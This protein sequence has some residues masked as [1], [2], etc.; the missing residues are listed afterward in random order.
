MAVNLNDSLYGAQF[1]AFQALADDAKL[2]QDTLVSVDGSGRGKG[3]LNE[4]GE[5][6]RIVVKKGDT[7]RPLFGRSQ[8]HVDLNNEV[9]DLFKET[10]LK[11]CGARTMDE[12]LQFARTTPVDIAFLDIQLGQASGLK[13]AEEQLGR[14]Y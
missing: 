14:K 7:I 3:L 11:V 1:R 5:S 12:A 13:L 9:R 6:R 8:G 10:V 2:G 4:A